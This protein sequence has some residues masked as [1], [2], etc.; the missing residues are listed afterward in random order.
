MKTIGYLTI[1]ELR[2]AFNAKSLWIFAL[3]YSVNFL[4]SALFFK[5]YG[6]EGTVLTVGNAQSFPI[7]HLQGNYLVGGLFMAIYV[8]QLIIQER[9]QG[10]MKLILLRAVS[11]RHYFISRILSIVVFSL[12]L[13]LIMLT[14]AYV[15]GWLAFGWGEELVFHEVTATG[16]SGVKLTLICGFAYSVAYFVFGIVSLVVSLVASK[17]LETVLIMG[18]TLIAGES[19]ELFPAINQFSL[20]HQLYFFGTDFLEKS[21]T[22]WLQNMGI[23]GVYLLIFG[24]IGYLVFRRQDLMI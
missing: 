7:Q 20:T 17:L 24:L 13:F 23:L 22:I 9:T 2:K 16:V 18:V 8:G 11:R 6:S 15:I 3:I 10:T 4:L 14:L 5:L 12:L 1:F 21:K 19:L